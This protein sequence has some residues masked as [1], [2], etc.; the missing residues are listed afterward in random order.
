MADGTATRSSRGHRTICLPI[1]EETYQRVVNDPREFRATIDE[2]FR[3]A[4]ELFP[5]AFAEGYQLKDDRVSAKQ[6]VLILRIVLNDGTAHS[7]RLSFLMLYM[8]GRVSDVEG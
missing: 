5:K 3:R 7:I 6:G 1:P 2:C 8:V 4:P